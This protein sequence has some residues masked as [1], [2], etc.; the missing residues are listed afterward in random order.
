MARLTSGHSSSQMC[1]IYNENEPT[2]AIERG[3]K[4]VTDGDWQRARRRRRSSPRYRER[5]GEKV[6]TDVLDAAFS[7][8]SRASV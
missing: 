8:N 3:I 5:A 1:R 7:S 6:H 2:C 4:N